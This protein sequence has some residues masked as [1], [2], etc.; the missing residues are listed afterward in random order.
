MNIFL[1]EEKSTTPGIDFNP[2]T[3]ILKL[4]GMSCAENSFKF[5]EPIYKWLEDYQKEA[6]SS[7]TLIFKLQYF[8]TSSAKCLYDVIDILKPL[9]E[10]GKN[11]TVEWHYENE[12]EDMRDAGINYS[13]LLDIP[14]KMIEYTEEY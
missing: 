14:F 2:T 10:K 1:L 7:T 5:F 12:D 6:P 3:G 4:T 8:N 11:L 13:D 9:I